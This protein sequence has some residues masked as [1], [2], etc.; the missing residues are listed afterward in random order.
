MTDTCDR[1]H[2]PKAADT[3]AW[4]RSRVVGGQDLTL[5]AAYLPVAGGKASK[6]HLGHATLAEAKDAAERAAGVE[7]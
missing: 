2:R 4:V 5:C 6:I 3:R 7:Q 1:C